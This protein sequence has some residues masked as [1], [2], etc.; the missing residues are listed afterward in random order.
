MN[1]AGILVK[2]IYI[3]QIS[4]VLYSADYKK[5]TEIILMEKVNLLRGVKYYYCINIQVL[6]LMG[7][8]KHDLEL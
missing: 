1:L 4:G 8:Q 5:Q 3:L 6:N 7:K 2:Y